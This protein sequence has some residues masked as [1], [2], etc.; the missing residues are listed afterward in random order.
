VAVKILSPDIVH[1]SDVG[2]VRLNL[3]SEQA[4]READH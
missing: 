1:K 3:T 2:G 4:V